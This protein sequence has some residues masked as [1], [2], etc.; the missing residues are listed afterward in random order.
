MVVP[1]EAR[2]SL[3]FLTLGRVNSAIGQGAVFNDF[4]EIR[5]L[6]ELAKIDLLSLILI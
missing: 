4:D 5:K 2:S 1:Q 6:I 3:R